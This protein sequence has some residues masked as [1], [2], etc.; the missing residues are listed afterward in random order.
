VNEVLG[1]RI[2][3]PF[4]MPANPRSIG[5]A[6]VPLSGLKLF[7]GEM[8]E[9]LGGESKKEIAFEVMRL[10]ITEDET[11]QEELK[12]Y[13]ECLTSVGV[14]PTTDELLEAAADNKAA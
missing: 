6:G 9:P 10:L 11:Y 13:S 5:S 1:Q 14:H 2:H 3:V 7:G 8:S 4:G 12:L